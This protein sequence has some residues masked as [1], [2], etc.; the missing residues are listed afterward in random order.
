MLLWGRGG[1]RARIIVYCTGAYWLSD[2]NRQRCFK[3]EDIGAAP[4]GLLWGGVVVSDCTGADVLPNINQ[5][6]CFRAQTAGTSPGGCYGD[7]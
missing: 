2:I 4:G 7:C 5:Q 1:G 3:T 6:W